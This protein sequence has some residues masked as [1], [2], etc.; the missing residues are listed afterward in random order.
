MVSRTSLPSLFKIVNSTHLPQAIWYSSMCLDIPCS[1]LIRI[2]RP[3]TCWKPGLLIHPQDLDWYLRMNCMY[4]SVWG[5]LWDRNDNSLSQG[6]D[7]YPAFMPYGPRFRKHQAFMHQFLEPSAV[8]AYI[9]LQM[10]EVHVLLNGLLS[11]PQNYDKHIRRWVARFCSMECGLTDLKLS[12]GDDPEY[13]L[14]SWRFVHPD[15]FLC[16]LKYCLHVVL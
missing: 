11:T 1:S 14:W 6:W 8:P 13:N 5:R 2:Q 16:V 10:R 4:S 15:T 12:W 3:W 7:W 9:P